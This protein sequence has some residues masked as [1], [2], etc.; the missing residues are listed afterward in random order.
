MCSLFLSTTWNAL[1]V[2]CSEVCNIVQSESS[3]LIEICHTIDQYYYIQQSERSDL[4][5]LITNTASNES[6]CEVIHD[7]LC[8]CMLSIKLLNLFLVIS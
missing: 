4:N 2:A 3:D 7:T 8:L 5:T 1:H 6:H